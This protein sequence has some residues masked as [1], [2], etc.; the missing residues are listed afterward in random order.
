MT[1]STR[2]TKGEW[3]STNSTIVTSGSAAPR[4]GR[5]AADTRK[6]AAG[7]SRAAART[8]SAEVAAADLGAATTAEPGVAPPAHAKRE[9]KGES[10]TSAHAG[11]TSPRVARRRA[12]DPT[13][14]SRGDAAGAVR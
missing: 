7:P 1:G 10:V 9:R 4:H 13:A 14:A 8:D 5:S 6:R 11:T 12:A 3:K 2:R